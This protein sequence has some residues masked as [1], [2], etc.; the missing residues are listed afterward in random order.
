MLIPTQVQRQFDLIVNEARRIYPAF[1]VPELVIATAGQ[2]AG[3]ARWRRRN[4]TV[5]WHID[6]NQIYLVSHAQDMLE[7]TLPHEIAHVLAWQRYGTDTQ[8]HGKEWIAMFGALTGRCPTRCHDYGDVRQAART[9][10]QL[11]TEA[12]NR[13]LAQLK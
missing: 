12:A 2:T 9:K 6:L 13:M 10:D 5:S 7:D 3:W 11:M 4:G 8:P 1:V